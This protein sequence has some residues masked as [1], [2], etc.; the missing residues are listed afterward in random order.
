MTLISTDC[1][2]KNLS[3]VKII[4]ASWHLKKDRNAL[5]EYKKTHIENAVFIDLD[6]VSNQEKNL[7]HNHFLPKKEKWEEILSKLGISSISFIII[8]SSS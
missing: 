3:K 2:N 5:E 1:L 6:K 8:R 7:P 4:D